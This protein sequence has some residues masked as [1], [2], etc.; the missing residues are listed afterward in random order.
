MGYGS[1]LHG[2]H[3]SYALRS[4]VAAR[5]IPSAQIIPHLLVREALLARQVNWDGKNVT[6]QSY[7][8]TC[9]PLSFASQVHQRT[10]LRGA[11]EQTFKRHRER[12]VK[13]NR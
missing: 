8:L 11:C 3:K 12:A 7:G 4:S 2:T 5:D 10:R 6:L 9:N 1:L 13:E